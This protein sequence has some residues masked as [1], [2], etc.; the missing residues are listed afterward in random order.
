MRDPILEEAL[1]RRGMV[2]KI[3]AHFGIS[4]AAVSRWRRVPEARLEGVA[5]VTGIKPAKLRPDLRKRAE[6]A[7]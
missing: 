4:P 3:A 6:K 7:A 2:K 1:Q 5:E